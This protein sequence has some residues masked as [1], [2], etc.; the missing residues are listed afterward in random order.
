MNQGTPALGKEAGVISIWGGNISHRHLGRKSKVVIIWEGKQGSPAFGEQRIAASNVYCSRGNQHLERE[1]CRV[2]QHFWEER[3]PAFGEGAMSRQHRGREA[4]LANPNIGG[5]KQGRQHLRREAGVATIWLA[6]G[7]QLYIGWEG[8]RY[9]EACSIWE[10]FLPRWSRFGN[11]GNCYIS[12]QIK[13]SKHRQ[14]KWINT[15]CP[16]PKNSLKPPYFT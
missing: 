12:S 2:R 4:G 10:V 14:I 9:P 6:N 11:I 1:A 16:C 8:G 5:G 7:G 13:C 15:R 3:L